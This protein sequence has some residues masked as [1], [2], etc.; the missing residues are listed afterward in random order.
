LCLEKFRNNSHYE[1]LGNELVHFKDD[2]KPA[3]FD[4]YTRCD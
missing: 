3:G 1:I 2:I 4:G